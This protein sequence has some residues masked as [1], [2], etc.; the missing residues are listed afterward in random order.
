MEGLPSTHTTSKVFFINKTPG[1]IEI[2]TFLTNER[3]L[4]ITCDML[5]DK[6]TKT[7]Q[8]LGSFKYPFSE[9]FHE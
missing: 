8:Q 4:S 7:V 2:K 1:I 9:I 3:D 6:S 5:Y